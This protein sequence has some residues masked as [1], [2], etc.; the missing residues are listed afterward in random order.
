MAQCDLNLFQNYVKQKA[1]K[2]GSSRQSLAQ[3][4]GRWRIRVN[5]KWCP[6]K[7]TVRT[8][9]RA[10]LFFLTFTLDLTAA[11]VLVSSAV[12]AASPDVSVSYCAP[13]SPA[14]DL[15]LFVG[16]LGVGVPLPEHYSNGTTQPVTFTTTMKAKTRR[17]P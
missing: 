2:C 3:H 15:T 17:F 13:A 16:D 6:M 10:V 14:Q 12:M 5:T 1:D 8:R 9:S 11:S 7:K 4:R